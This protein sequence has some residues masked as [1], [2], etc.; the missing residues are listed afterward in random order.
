[1]LSTSL[2]IYL[3]YDLDLSCHLLSDHI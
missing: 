3:N 1:M 2:R